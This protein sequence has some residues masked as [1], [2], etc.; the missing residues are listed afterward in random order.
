MGVRA[1][2]GKAAEGMSN[3]GCLRAAGQ[4]LPWTMTECKLDCA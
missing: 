2:W 3:F 4:V 1:K